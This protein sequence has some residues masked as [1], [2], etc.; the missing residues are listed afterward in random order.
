M[1]KKCILSAELAAM[2][3]R[4][5]AYE[6]MEHNPDASAITIAGIQGNGVYVAG[7]VADLLRSISTLKV[8]TLIVLMDK[9]DPLKVRLSEPVSIDGKIIVLVDDVSNSGKVLLYALKPFLEGYPKKIQTLVLLERSHK[10][11]PIHPDYVGLSLST[12][13]KE[14]ISV[15]IVNGQVDSAWL[16]EPNL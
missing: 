4:R 2:K 15:E 16:E 5:M 9:T 11:Y 8:E 10:T 13:L 7:Q 14:N 12:M 6:I 1:E 3:L